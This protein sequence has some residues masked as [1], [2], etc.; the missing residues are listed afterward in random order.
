L[1]KE[2]SSVELGHDFSSGQCGAIQGQVMWEGAAPAIEAFRQYG[3]GDMPPRFRPNSNAPK[4]DAAS[5]G[6]AGAM[7]FLHDL[8]PARSRL[9]DHGPVKVI[10]SDRQFVLYQGEQEAA[11]GIARRGD[12]VEITSH[13]DVYHLVRGRGA[14][15]FALPLVEKGRGTRRRLGHSGFV[16]LSSAAGH[17]WMRAYVVVAEH[18]Y[19]AVTDDQGRFHLPQ[20][21]AGTYR[22]ACWLPD[23]HVSRKM[24]DQE[25]THVIGVEFARAKEKEIGVQVGAGKSTTA[26]FTW[27]LVDFSQ[28]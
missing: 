11:T 2:G 10:L 16:E 26:H 25:T 8:D 24:R 5:Q 17:Y 19:Y 22:L 21:P 18:P 1:V 4:I 28:P 27:S 6:I 3:S 23:W 15:F 9:W 13:D 7:V 14:D 20:V 12:F